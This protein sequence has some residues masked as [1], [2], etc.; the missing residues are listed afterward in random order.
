MQ[1]KQYTFNKIRILSK[2]RNLIRHLYIHIFYHVIDM[3]EE[4]MKIYT[5]GNLIFL[6]I[7]LNIVKR[8]ES[9]LCWQPH[10]K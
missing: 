10:K 4:V 7:N 5:E 6:H 8:V 9:K 3:M 1:M 2:K